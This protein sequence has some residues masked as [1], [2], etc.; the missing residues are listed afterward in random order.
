MDNLNRGILPGRD[1]SVNV[2]CDIC[3]RIKIKAVKSCLDCVAS[4]C[5]EHLEPHGKV[6][7]FMRHKM[8][9]PLEDLEERVCEKHGRPLEMFCRTDQECVCMMCNV[10]DHKDHDMVTLETE[11]EERKNKTEKDIRISKDFFNAFRHSLAKSQAE[12]QAPLENI[13]QSTQTRAK[14]LNKQLRRGIPDLQMRRAEI[15]QIL[16]TEDHLHLLKSFPS[17]CNLP[18]V[19]DCSDIKVDSDPGVGIPIETLTELRNTINQAFQKMCNIVDVTLDPDTAHPNLTLTE[20]LKQTKLV[21]VSQNLPNNPMPHT[22]QKV[23]VFVDYEGGQVSFYDVD[24]RSHIY[25][26][27]SQAF[28]EA[29]YPYLSPWNSNDVKNL[30]LLVI[31][32]V[33]VC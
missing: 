1:L 3:H 32:S 16:L 15:E 20:D 13:Q 28:S 22:H 24:N 14:E 25:S 6:A 23:A 26:Y 21:I 27:T 7:S 11:S 2:L 8:V 5:E 12:H 31:S 33:G 9:A 17:L 18:M 29:P 30:A 19:E 10:L 4:Y